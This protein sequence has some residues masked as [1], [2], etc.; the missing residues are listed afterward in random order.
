MTAI[1]K[2]SIKITRATRLLLWKATEQNVIWKRNGKNSSFS[3]SYKNKFT[4]LL[5]TE[6]STTIHK[7][8]ETMTL[9]SHT[10]SHSLFLFLVIL[11]VLS[12]ICLQK[13][14]FYQYQFHQ[15]PPLAKVIKE[16]WV[17]KRVKGGEDLRNSDWWKANKCLCSPVVS[18]FFCNRSG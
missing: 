11:T 13:L 18:I 4:C 14:C 3:Y 12:P 7:G 9:K 8:S 10:Y 1:S 6:V 16:E 5:H 15:A 17:I 2:W